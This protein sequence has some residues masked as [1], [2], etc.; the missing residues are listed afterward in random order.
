MKKVLGATLETVIEL[1]DKKIETAIN[2]FHFRDATEDIK[3]DFYRHLIE[4]DRLKNYDP[5]IAQLNTYIYTCLRYYCLRLRKSSFYKKRAGLAKTISFY[6]EHKSQ[7]N[8]N[9][10]EILKS[11]EDTA[12]Q[13]E[14]DLFVRDVLKE[15]SNKHYILIETTNDVKIPLK[16]VL[17]LLI[18]GYNVNEIERTLG[19][20]SNVIANRIERLS[21][22]PFIKEY[23]ECR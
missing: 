16:K 17:E 8:F 13:V 20:T 18:L 21:K 14:E 5:G 19:I 10:L 4:K 11:D 9:L 23:Y 15:S 6:N 12:K 3:Q 7:E 22:R 1:M 2:N